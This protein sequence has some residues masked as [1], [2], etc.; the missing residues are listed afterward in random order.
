MGIYELL[1][2]DDEIKALINRTPDSNDIRRVALEKGLITL[3]R[4]GAQKVVDGFT[5]VE[6]VVRVTQA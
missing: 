3:R 6:E 4:D 5:T 2:L 1:L